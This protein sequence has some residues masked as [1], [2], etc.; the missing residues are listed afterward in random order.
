[1][2]E[3]LHTL[4]GPR[5]AEGILAPVPFASALLTGPFA[6]EEPPGTAEHPR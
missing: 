6:E 4:Q 1:M 5:E 3:V 2:Q